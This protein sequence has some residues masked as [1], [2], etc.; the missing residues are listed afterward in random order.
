MNESA[1][2]VM[3]DTFVN[4]IINECNKMIVTGISLDLLKK[5]LD[6]V[7]VTFEY[8]KEIPIIIN[9][10]TWNTML[11]IISLIYFEQ[12]LEVFGS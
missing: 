12:M 3:K 4:G 8:L 11:C 10:N 2:I 9:E 7:F 6:H 5:R 1:V